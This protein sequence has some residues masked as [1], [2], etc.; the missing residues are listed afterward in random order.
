MVIGG[1]SVGSESRRCSYREGTRDGRRTVVGCVRRLAGR[2]A[3]GWST[4]GASGGLRRLMGL[5]V[6]SGRVGSWVGSDDWGWSS[7]YSGAVWWTV[8]GKLGEGSGWSVWIRD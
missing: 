8:E 4:L 7:S 6:W 1:A 3:V 5:V 2:R